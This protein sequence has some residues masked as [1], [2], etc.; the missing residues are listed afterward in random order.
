[1]LMLSSLEQRC[2]PNSIKG[3]QPALSSSCSHSPLKPL[4]LPQL[5]MLVW[6]MEEREPATFHTSHWASVRPLLDVVWSCRLLDFR[7]LFLNWTMPHNFN[8]ILIFLY[9]LQLY[10]RPQWT[11]ATIMLKER[12]S[13]WRGLRRALTHSLCQLL[14]LQEGVETDSVSYV[15]LLETVHERIISC[16]YSTCPY[17]LLLVC[18]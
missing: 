13:H 4:C 5:L 9:S 8:S 1:M 17:N 11:Y 6:V 14:N 15:F 12:D 18:S 3:A 7:T 2:D 10:I 16:C